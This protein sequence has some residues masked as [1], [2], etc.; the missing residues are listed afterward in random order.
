MINYYLKEIDNVAATLINT[1]TTKVLLIQGEM[2]VG[3]TTLIKA[4]VKKLGSS[5]EVGSPTFSIVNEYMTHEGDS[6]Y[7]FDLYRLDSLEEAHD[8]GIEEY[9]YSGH[10]C[11]IEWPDIVKDSLQTDFEIIEICLENDKSRSLKILLNQSNEA[12]NHVL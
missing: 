8:F 4:L 9:L 12:P 3:K 2:G 11:F 7:H 5:D 10:W 6:I 1:V